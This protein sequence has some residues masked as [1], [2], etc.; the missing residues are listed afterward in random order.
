MSRQI[1]QI[2]A[3]IDAIAP[4]D[5][6]QEW[7]N[8]GL[9]VG[10]PHDEAARVLLCL[11]VT[12]DVIAEARELGAAL[13]VAHHPLI[14]RPLE[15]LRTDQ[16]AGRLIRELLDLRIALFVAHTN[17]DAAPD[18]GSA[19]ALADLLEVEPDGPLIE[20]SEVGLG[21]VGNIPSGISVCDLVERVRERLQPARIVQVGESDRTVHRL[22]L[23]PGSGG[24]AVGAA[25]AAG[26]DALICGDLKHHD[27]LDAISLGLTVIDATHYA[28]E[29]PVLQSL[30]GHLRDRLGN[31]VEIVVSTVVTDP[32]AGA[33]R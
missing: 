19:A 17:L 28:S 15:A 18:L 31:D 32:F 12:C 4:P 30:A 8:V 33:S 27:A 25:A 21:C 13:I 6:A 9:Q 10:D 3:E 29:R 20:S 24:D 23:M 16:P 1:A 14:F 5:T 22:A 26:A 7:D 2:T 11:E